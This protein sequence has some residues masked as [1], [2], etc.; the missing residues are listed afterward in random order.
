MKKIVQ[1]FTFLSM[2][3]ASTTG[4]RAQDPE[5]IA[6]QA[7]DALKEAQIQ[8]RD[9]QELL[10]QVQNQTAKIAG[11]AQGAQ[12]AVA[13]TPLDFKIQ[14]LAHGWGGRPG[15]RPLVI[16]SSEPDPK[17]HANLEEDL[18]VMSHLLDKALEGKVGGQ[19]KGETAMGIN[20]FFNP[21][22]IPVRS[23]FLEDYGVVFFLNVNFPLIAPPKGEPDKEKPSTDS[24]WEEAKRELY[25]QRDGVKAEPTPVEEFDQEKV[26]IL[27]TALIEALKNASNIRGLKPDETITISVSGAAGGVFKY[28]QAKQ[29]SNMPRVQAFRTGPAAAMTGSTLT[30]RV[31]KS[32]VDGFSRNKLSPDE[33][34]KKV[35]IAVYAVSAR[36]KESLVGGWESAVEAYDSF[37]R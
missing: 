29:S 1:V 5:E 37:V 8:N 2:L 16:R 13:F 14:S 7:E 27:K 34:R 15:S 18:M 36:E 17:D 19:R 28:K 31:K 21:A 6:R 20:L 3:V 11:G 12:G 32:D 24:T 9:Q 23:I 26:D 25:G 35:R 10:R 4:S 22:A 30:L 33:F